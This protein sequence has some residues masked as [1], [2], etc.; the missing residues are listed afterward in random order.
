MKK[1][2]LYLS[3]LAALSVAANSCISEL[4]PNPVDPP[5][6][7]DPTIPTFK[8][9]Y[10]N[11]ITE[12]IEKINTYAYPNL[13]LSIPV[14][15]W[16]TSEHA[17]VFLF[18]DNNSTIYNNRDYN[19][20]ADHT[21]SGSRTSI[22]TDTVTTAVQNAVCYA[23][24]PYRS[25]ISGRTV[26]YQLDSVQ[27]QSADLSGKNLMDEAISHNMFMIAPTTDTFKLSGGTGALYF[28]SVFSIVRFQVTRSP[29]D[30]SA[31]QFF[32]QRIKQVQLYVAKKSD[33]S[34]PLDYSLAGSYTIDVSKPIAASDYT[35]PVFTSRRNTIKATVTGGNVISDNVNNSPYAWFIVNPVKLNPDECLVTVVETER[36]RIID[37][38]GIAELKVN[39]AY[40]IPV[41][42][43]HS[44]TLSSQDPDVYYLKDRA[45]NCYIISRSGLYQIPLYTING[46]E[47]LRGSSVDWL[48]A[49][50]ENGAANF[51][52]KELVDPSSFVY[53]ENAT[54]ENDNYIRFRVGTNFGVYTKGNVI[55]ALKDS[56][57][58]I[59]WTW[60]IWITDEPQDV[61]YSANKKFLDRNIGAFS[62]EM[63]TSGIDNYGFVYQWGR[64]DPFFGG[65]GHYNETA[66]TPLAFATDYT[67]RN[68]GV[69]WSATSSTSTTGTTGYATQNPTRFIY[70]PTSSNNLEAPVDWLIDSDTT[71]W[72]DSEKTDNDPCPYGY[73]V[74]SREDLKNLLDAPQSVYWYFRNQGHWHW[75][76]HYRDD[77][78]G[79]NTLTA[80]PAAGKRQGRYNYRENVGAQLTVGAQ[81]VNSGT[82]AGAGQCYYWTS[83]SVVLKDNSE[84]TG[85]SHRIFTSGSTLYSRDDFGDN[86]DAYPIR[87]VKMD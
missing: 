83:T 75:D 28:E 16:G 30:F 27:N 42:A 25:A 7:V 70:N 20:N 78:D 8:T 9:F 72:M 53:S 23:Y 58:R 38:C 57:G 22:F 33:L 24:Y 14:I 12:R 77:Y 50:K 62:A 36:H 32:Q 26:S 21:A 59:V 29:S 65:D 52:I 49:S 80:F 76:F 10:L 82:A 67:I 44:N 47:P 35:G 85:G 64:K 6:T 1:I 48:W 61:N 68:T 41:V 60:H 34:K 66:A 81:L 13:G 18:G 31:A 73:K 84:L 11:F 3:I 71:L 54:S 46:T 86:A 37:T 87:C 79:I 5:V 51:D 17:G 4:V 69:S 39:N 15:W 74:P 40:S 2:F 56:N 19:I 55:L 45:S 63:I 43:K